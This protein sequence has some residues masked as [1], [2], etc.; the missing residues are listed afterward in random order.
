V[1]SGALR[2]PAIVSRFGGGTPRFRLLCLPQAGGTA[3]SFATWRPVVPAGVEVATIGLPGRGIRAAEPAPATVQ[4]LADSLVG[5]LRDAVTSPYALF[6]HSFGALVAYELTRR[7]EL[8]GL[9]A[10]TALLVSASRP[11]HDPP[12]GRVSQLDDDGLLRWLERIGGVPPELRRYTRFLRYAIDTIRTDLALAERFRVAEPAPVHCD[13]RVFGGSGDVLAPREQ[14]E[15]WRPC[16]AAG[17][18]VTVLPG[19]H[20]YPYADPRRTLTALLRAAAPPSPGK[21]IMA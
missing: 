1:T 21:E 20:A 8:A 12:T 6:G 19:G 18:S 10:P 7:L 9:P 16:A 4:E 14:L 5:D 2:T 3:S 15:S 17:F 11:P 13:L